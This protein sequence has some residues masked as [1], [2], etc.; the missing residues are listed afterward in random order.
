MDAPKT[1]I[2]G[3]NLW[4]ILHS[5]AERIGTCI[6]K[7]LPQ[8]ES[9]IWVGL[10]RSL[11]FTLP[12]PQCKKHYAKYLST[13]PIISFTKESIRSWLF[14][15]HDLVNQ[16]TGKTENI[17]ALEQIPSIYEQPFHFSKHVN[18]VSH[19][20]SSAVKLGWSSYDDTKRTIRLFE[21]M[22]RFYDFF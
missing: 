11:Q 19:Q 20:M 1:C 18:V 3:P 4:T 22:R 10:L 7:R 15:L 5:A 17:L 21:E 9:R 16:D 14:V 12:C 2:W 8:E 6:L 13:H